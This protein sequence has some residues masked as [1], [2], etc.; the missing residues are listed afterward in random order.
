[1]I[2]I[3][4]CPRGLQRSLSSLSSRQIHENS[5]LSPSLRFLPTGQA[6]AYLGHRELPVP[7]HHD[8]HGK[9]FLRVQPSQLDDI[10]DF[11]YHRRGRNAGLVLANRLSED[12]DYAVLAAEAGDTGDAVRDSIGAFP[13]LRPSLC[14][15][16]VSSFPLI[17]AIPIL[18][19]FLE[20][21]SQHS[22]GLHTIGITRRLLRCT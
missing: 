5:L 13:A 15:A 14:L 2:E 3:Y 12:S 4:N 22:L 19:M 10:Y 1:M 17:F 18:Q 8:L 20:S 7:R 11:M 9:G 21:H 16:F 6:F